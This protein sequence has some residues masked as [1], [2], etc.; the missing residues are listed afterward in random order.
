MDNNMSIAEKKKKILIVSDMD[1]ENAIALITFELLRAAKKIAKDT[2]TEINSFTITFQNINHFRSNIIV[3]AHNDGYVREMNRRLM[4]IEGVR[5]L[6][7]DFPRFLPHM[8][9]AQF[10]CNEEH[11]KLV[12]KLEELRSVSIGEMKISQLDL[13][14][15]ILP[16]KG[17]YPILE[18]LD[19]Y[20]LG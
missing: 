10:K 3:E 7:Y 18:V 1:D 14:K 19:S 8:S 17:R 15:A 5:K 20:Q 2:V 4:E 11:D 13:V 12:D 16:T 6:P 9:V